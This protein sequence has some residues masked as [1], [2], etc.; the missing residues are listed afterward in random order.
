MP[1][2]KRAKR[3]STSSSRRKAFKEPPAF[4]RLT[5][6]LD[7]AQEALAELSKQ[8]GRDVGQSASAIS[9][10]LRTFVSNARRHSGRLGKA[11]SRDF[12][13]AQKKLAKA[14][15]SAS[16]GG[17]SSR[18]SSRRT[19]TSRGAS[20]RTASR[21]SSTARGKRKSTSAKSSGRSAKK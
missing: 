12:E 4:K 8:S 19:A 13:Q 11:L 18:T 6:S 20:T 2:A 9:K 21:S 17:G 16:A 3:S 15:S 5:K 1:P 14:T 7:T 10:D